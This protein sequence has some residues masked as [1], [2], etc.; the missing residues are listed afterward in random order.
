MPDIHKSINKLLVVFLVK[1]QVFF[2]RL[3]TRIVDQGLCT[4]M[5]MPVL[6]HIEYT[7]CGVSDPL[8]DLQVLH[9]ASSFPHSFGTKLKF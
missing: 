4:N 8:Q 9:Y 5:V 1:T 3:F 6:T 2:L 7:L